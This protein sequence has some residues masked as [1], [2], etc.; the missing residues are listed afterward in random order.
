MR[1]TVAHLLATK[2][3]DVWSVAP[4][5]TVYDALQERAEKGRRRENRRDGLTAVSVALET[6]A[7]AK[8]RWRG[9][10]VALRELPHL[11]RVDPGGAGGPVQ[12]P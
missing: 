11:P 9:L 2:G 6:P 12:R 1:T 8:E 4:T 5:T 7:A 3:R 10:V